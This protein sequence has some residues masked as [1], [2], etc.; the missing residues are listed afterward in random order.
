MEKIN[1]GE[2]MAQVLADFVNNM[3]YQK[4]QFSEQV[5]YR[6]HRTL[7]QSIMELFMNT[8]YE[9]SKLE[10]YS[11]DLRN[12]FT[13]KLAKKIIDHLTKDGSLYIDS[14]RGVRFPFI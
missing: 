9:W 12:E 13:V 4:S 3:S 1:N 10:E 6:T 7:Q 11:Y 8:I 2:E 5:I 14:Q